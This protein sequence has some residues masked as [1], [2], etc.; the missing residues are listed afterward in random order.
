MRAIVGYLAC[1]S[2]IVLDHSPGA[3]SDAGTGVYNAGYCGTS[4]FK[5]L[6]G[7]FPVN[8]PAETLSPCHLWT[9]DV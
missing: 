7:S 5:M 8:G 4:T 1:L 6:A 3:L 2:K 9:I